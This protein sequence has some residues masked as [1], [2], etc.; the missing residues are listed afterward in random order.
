MSFDLDG[1]VYTVDN[2]VLFTSCYFTNSTHSAANIAVTNPQS[3]YLDELPIILTY[4][5]IDRYNGYSCFGLDY[6]QRLIGLARTEPGYNK[7]P[8]DGC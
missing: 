5:F 1:Q 4:G 3:R 8:R 2:R 7:N 6:E